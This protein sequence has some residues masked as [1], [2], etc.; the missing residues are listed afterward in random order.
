MKYPAFHLGDQRRSIV[1]KAIIETC[2][3]RSWSL[4]ALNVRTNHVHVALGSGQKPGKE[5]LVALKVNSTRV[6]R[7]EALC[8][9]RRSPWSKGG[10]V[11]FI[12]D[13]SALGD[14]VDYVLNDQSEDLFWNDNS[15]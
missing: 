11:R 5:V 10:S 13:I 14:V 15:S 3:F 2:E 6:L 7:N 8:E 4:H 9:A 1:R 12:W